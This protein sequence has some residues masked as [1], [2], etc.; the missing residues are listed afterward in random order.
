MTAINFTIAVMIYNV[1]KFLPSTIKSIM[2]QSGDDIEILLI[3]DGSTDSSGEICD[4]YEAKDRRIH[5]IHQ[6]NSGVAAARNTALRNAKGKWLIMVDGDD[7]LVS[8]AIET[9]R[10][11]L[12][13][14]AE[15]LQFDAIPFETAL[16]EEKWIPKGNERVLSA[17][18]LC[19]YHIH[20]I[21]RTDVGAIY[22]VY[23]INPAWGKM[24]NMD[25]IRENG[26]HYDAEV[27]KGEGTLFTFTASYIM[28]R[29]RM[30][31]R[32]LYG[33]RINPG[34]IMH[35]FS[36]DILENQSVQWN[37]YYDMICR[38]GEAEQDAVMGALNR[39]GLYLIENAIHLGIAH[40]DCPWTRAEKMEWVRKLCN[41]PWVQSSVGYANATTGASTLQML[42][43][44]KNYS[45]V[46]KFCER[47]RC[48]RMVSDV[49]GKYAI[50]KTVVSA[51]KRLRQGLAVR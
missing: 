39:R 11:Y 33:Y 21:D 50:A 43:Q 23:N 18:E 4:Q 30:I 13:E 28:K 22:P 36:Q 35:R 19:E 8:D 6:K 14:S 42:I 32:P 37:K 20:L 41:L 10:R 47:L 3:D 15:L 25:F 29:V 40:P 34:S 49:V 12:D 24:W 31:P 44:G 45:G 9:G 51:L 1:E 48:R 26:L 16:H 27:N 2:N 17:D 46:T 5:T 7:V 38:N